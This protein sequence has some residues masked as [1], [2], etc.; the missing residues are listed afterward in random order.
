MTILET[1]PVIGFIHRILPFG[2]LS[3]SYDGIEEYIDIGL[4]WSNTKRAENIGLL[5]DG[6]EVFLQASDDALVVHIAST[7]RGNTNVHI[8]WDRKQKI[9]NMLEIRDPDHNNQ[10]VMYYQ[11]A[12]QN[13]RIPEALSRLE[14]SRNFAFMLISIEEA[15]YFHSLGFRS[16]GIPDRK[17]ESQ[18]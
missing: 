6:R 12:P 5:R 7:D 16:G 15:R 1:K 13:E 8:R 14:V 9:V 18:L 11:I 10:Q 17:G 2:I 3:P 4:E